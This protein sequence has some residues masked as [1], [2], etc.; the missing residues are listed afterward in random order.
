M[1][2]QVFGSPNRN[3]EEF[4]DAEQKTDPVIRLISSVLRLSCLS[5]KLIEVKLSKF[6]YGFY[7]K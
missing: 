2:L 5:Q 3:L 7:N 4:A 6:D 1:T